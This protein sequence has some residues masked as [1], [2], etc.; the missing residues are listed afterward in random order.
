M[1]STM[2]YSLS[3][4]EQ[5]RLQTVIAVCFAVPFVDDVENF[6]WEAAFHYVKALP[7]PNPLI[8]GR[9]KRLF[10]AVDDGSGIGWS[11]KA[12]Q[13]ANLATGAQFELV[14]QRADVFK[15]AEAL[16]FDTLTVQSPEQDLGRALIR[17]W[18]RKTIADSTYQGVADP[19]VGILVKNRARTQF[20]FVEAS[21]PPF[22][23]GAFE[24]RWTNPQRE[25]L[26]GFLE[27]RLKLR[28]YPNQKQLFEVFD[29]PAQATRVSLVPARVDPDDFIDAVM[30]LLHPED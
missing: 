27:G 15:K 11:L 28:W 18:N 10:D 20:V 8:Q 25:G 7:I 29:V 16:G 12:L 30:A 17:H 3:D 22:D 4:E 19:R 23:E 13:R 26:Q 1:S 5:R 14:I 6:I 2:Y 24:W 9:T 21:Y